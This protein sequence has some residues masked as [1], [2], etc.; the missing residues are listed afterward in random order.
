M[1]R[2]DIALHPIALAFGILSVVFILASVAAVVYN[3]PT[4]RRS[5]T[6][7]GAHDDVRPFVPERHRQP[8]H[9]L[10]SSRRG[11]DRVDNRPN[12]KESTSARRNREDT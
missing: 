10:T 2:L 5:Q 7:P 11:A 1:P 3:T 4:S 8:G 6:T 9:H 12:P